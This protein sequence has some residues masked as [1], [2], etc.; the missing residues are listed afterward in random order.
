MRINLSAALFLLF[1][2]IGFCQNSEFKTYDN[3]L[4]Y[5]ET[6]MGKLKYIVDSLNLKFKVCDKDK[7]YRSEKTAIVNYLK[8]ESDRAENLKKDIESGMDFK[9][10]LAKYPEANRRQNL[11]L[12]KFIHHNRYSKKDVI[13]YSTVETES[14]SNF[15]LDF[16]EVQNEQKGSW[17]F[18][19]YEKSKYSEATMTC[20]Y[21]VKG[22]SNIKLPNKYSQ[23]V[24]YSECLID[25]GSSVYFKD[26]KENIYQ[27]YS[28][29]TNNSYQKFNA[30][31]NANLKKPLY[32]S[33]NFNRRQQLLSI[34]NSNKP[35]D[36]AQQALNKKEMEKLDKEYVDY[37]DRYTKWLKERPAKIDSL[38]NNNPKFL[39]LLNETLA[40][41]EK[42]NYCVDKETE[43]YIGKYISK[44]KELSL[45]RG[46]IV[47]GSCSMDTGPR[48]HAR[49][50]TF[51]AAETYNWDVFIRSH[52]DLMSDN[53]ES[54]AYS[55]F[56]NV[57]K[58]T[59]LKELEELNINSVDLLLGIVLRIDNPTQNHYYGNS[60]RI[61]QALADSQHKDEF[62]K[63][64]LEMI[65]DKK[66]D[67][68]NRVMIFCL[69]RNY[70]YILKDETRK[71]INQS[72]LQTLVHKLPDYIASR[73]KI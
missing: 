45:K 31:V 49:D 47:T 16:K 54:V 55:N 68:Y 46:R 10:V 42:N 73:V 17:I 35:I 27:I 7:T 2:F 6:T 14:D 33:E 66:L 65:S 72:N 12:T 70:T 15:Y 57:G 26:A 24:Q 64:A 20:F 18:K 9:Q 53:F 40:F 5:S 21:I 23:L 59:Y 50:I 44:E 52:L 38:K 3:G 32:P 51:L 61:A 19:Y 34:A 8:L 39:L 37:Y 25:P 62:E 56:G 36:P 58:R 48:E 28:D 71:K 4:I 63:K 11:M 29:T 1:N 13:Y 43:S 30:F 60:S 69:F 67:D 22:F 41:I